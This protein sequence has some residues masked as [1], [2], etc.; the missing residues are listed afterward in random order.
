MSSRESM[1][2][3]MSHGV[4]TVAISALRK[5]AFYLLYRTIETAMQFVLDPFVGELEHQLRSP[6]HE[7]AVSV[8]SSISRNHDIVAGHDTATRCNVR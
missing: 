7:R 1:R 3:N 5:H 8:I 4:V 6:A 2:W